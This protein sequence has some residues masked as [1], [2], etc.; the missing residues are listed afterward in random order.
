[1][2]D[3]PGLQ[4]DL[5]V[6]PAGATVCSGPFVDTRHRHGSGCTF[7]AA[8]TARLA[9]GDSVAAAVQAARDFVVR[10]L[11]SAPGLGTVGPLNHW[12]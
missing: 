9:H 7:S 10:A 3:V 11:A 4:G 2:K 12:A 5:L 6:G 1:M 8:L